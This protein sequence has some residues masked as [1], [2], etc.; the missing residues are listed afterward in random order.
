MENIVYF[1]WKI[2]LC[3]SNGKYLG[4]AIIWNHNLW[5]YLGNDACW[6]WCMLGMM[7]VDGG[8]ISQNY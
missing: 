4:K 5:N 7:H 6:E 1:K 8:D 3:I 2:E